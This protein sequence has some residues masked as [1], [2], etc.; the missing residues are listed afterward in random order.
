MGIQKTEFLQRRLK[1]HDLQY[2]TELKKKNNFSNYLLK[3]FKLP[4]NFFLKKFQ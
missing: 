1:I 3:S 2:L 4:S